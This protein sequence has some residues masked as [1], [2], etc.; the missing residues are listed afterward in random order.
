MAGP[1]M[2]RPD[3]M[4]YA[5]LAE[6]AG[7]LTTAQ[8]NIDDPAPLLRAMYELLA[9]ADRIRTHVPTPKSKPEREIWVTI[10][11]LKACYKRD[12]PEIETRSPGH[13][14]GCRA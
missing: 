1:A 11:E 12:R 2:T 13:V 5:H 3:C 6:A 4:T 14:P 8:G 7:K 9:L 10:D